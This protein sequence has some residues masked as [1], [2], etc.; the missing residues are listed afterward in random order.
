[1][2]YDKVVDS[3]VLDAGLKQIAD[4]I[5]EKGGTSD[6]LAFPTAMAEAIAAIEAGG[7]GSFATGI[8]TPAADTQTLT[9]E[10]G[11]GT[12]DL[13][14]FAIFSLDGVGSYS[15]AISSS[16]ACSTSNTQSFASAVCENGGTIK[17]T[18]V[19]LSNQK[20]GPLYD[21]P[22]SGV[23]DKNKIELA[24]NLGI[25]P[26]SGATFVFKG[27]NRYFWLIGKV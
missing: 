7:G 10:H 13:N 3:A 25:Y 18:I 12:D 20:Y 17:G 1:M 8:I 6:T 2:A 16:T 23:Q 26:V 4:A 22:T 5:R 24:T 21:V 27:G 14:V 15:K 11:L 19:T 9:I